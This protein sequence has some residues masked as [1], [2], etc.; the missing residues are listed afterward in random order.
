MNHS[1]CLL[2]PTPKPLGKV[3]SDPRIDRGHKAGGKSWVDSRID[4]A[5]KGGGK[6]W[7]ELFPTTTYTPSPSPPQSRERGGKTGQD[8]DKTWGMGNFHTPSDRTGL[9]TTGPRLTTWP[10][11]QMAHDPS[12]WIPRL[13]PRILLDTTLPG[14]PLRLH[15]RLLR[16][17]CPHQCW[18]LKRDVDCE[19]ARGAPLRTP[20]RRMTPRGQLVGEE[21]WIA[22]V[23]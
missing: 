10:A 3:G 20:P 13:H 11:R 12:Q 4:R 18:Y 14:H 17:R 21:D 8:S 15:L 6:S 9:K 1:I 19:V 7:V 2:D 23:T 22:P 5:Y 16:R